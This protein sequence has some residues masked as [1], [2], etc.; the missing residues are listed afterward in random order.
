MKTGIPLRQ[1]MLAARTAAALWALAASIPAAAQGEVRLSDAWLRPA[2][3]GQPR[4]SVYV[5]IRATAAMKLVGAGTPVARRA[6]LVVADPS[7]P[8]PAKQRVVKE[9]AIAANA[10]TRLAY[11][12]NHV[13]LIDIKQDLK[14]GEVI[15]LELTFT[16]GTGKRRTATTEAL[17]RGISAKRP[18]DA[19]PP[20]A[21]TPPKPATAK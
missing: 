10:D 11:L 16:D 15:K 3:Q 14:P 12:G 1:R 18:A 4:A 6:E 5:D 8:D 20:A 7:D 17:V 21:G 2:Y 9:L 19:P 13:R